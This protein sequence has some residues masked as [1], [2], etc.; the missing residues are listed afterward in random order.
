MTPPSLVFVAF[1][2]MHMTGFAP[3]ALK[4]T[5]TGWDGAEPFDINWPDPIRIP[6]GTQISISSAPVPTSGI[7]NDTRET[8][9]L[10]LYLF[11]RPR[12]ASSTFLDLWQTDLIYAASLGRNQST[13][14]DRGQAEN[15]ING[16]DLIGQNFW[17]ISSRSKQSTYNNGLAFANANSY[18]INAASNP[19]RQSIALN[20]FSQPI[21]PLKPLSGGITNT[22]RLPSSDK[23]WFGLSYVQG[24]PSKVAKYAWKIVRPP[25][26]EIK[27]RM[28]TKSTYD[29]QL[30]YLP[31]DISWF[32][33][34]TIPAE[35]LETFDPELVAVYYNDPVCFIFHPRFYHIPYEVIV[36]TYNKTI[37]E[38]QTD[39]NIQSFN[40]MISSIRD[41][42]N[43]PYNSSYVCGPSAGWPSFEIVT[44]HAA[45][46]ANTDNSTN[47]QEGCSVHS[48]ACATDLP[49][50]VRLPCA[51]TPPNGLVV[52]V[53]STV[54]DT[55]TATELSCTPTVSYNDTYTA[56]STFPV[57]TPENSNASQNMKALDFPL[58]TLILVAL[59]SNWLF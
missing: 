39:E 33:S 7:Q 35:V 45:L 32:S 26:S 56:N 30:E 9:G 58:G 12:G 37:K 51:T 21:T 36:T 3:P 41:N 5:S 4:I 46:T 25:G 48:T 34:I 55:I 8:G 23:E 47:L 10:P 24:I 18:I 15:N 20:A 50:T 43:I 13:S 44:M 59:I 28:N 29:T 54:T 22:P 27:A 52:T 2:A 1:V 6:T 17:G 19:N 38:T 40:K 42:Q 53:T 57:P 31:W 16:P 14:I 49:S 11:T